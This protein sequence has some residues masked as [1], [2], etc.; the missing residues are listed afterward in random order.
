MTEATQADKK[1]HTLVGTVVSDKMDKSIVV[2]IEHK[3]KHALYGKYISRTTKIHAH[4]EANEARQ[5]DKVSVTPCRPMSKKKS[6]RLAEVIDKAA[7]A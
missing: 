7:V 1:L 4:D 5:G 2:A 6:F 3:E